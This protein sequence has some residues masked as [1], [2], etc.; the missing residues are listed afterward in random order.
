MTVTIQPDRA[1]SIT[2]RWMRVAFIGLSL[3]MV[4]IYLYIRT[5]VDW[6]DPVISV[7]THLRNYFLGAFW[8][9]ITCFNTILYFLNISIHGWRHATLLN[10]LSMIINKNGIILLYSLCGIIMIEIVIWCVYCYMNFL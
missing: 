6:P 2:N 10:M 4:S 9:S 8:L 3:G 5:Y 1:R 7:I